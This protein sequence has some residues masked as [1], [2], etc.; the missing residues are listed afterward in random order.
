MASARPHHDRL[1]IRGG[2]RPAALALGRVHRSAQQSQPL[3]VTTAITTAEQRFSAAVSQRLRQLGALTTG[4]PRRRH[5]R[6]LGEGEVLL[7][8][9]GNRAA[10]IVGDLNHISVRKSHP[11]AG[12]CSTTR[13]ACRP[14]TRV[15]SSRALRPR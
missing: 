10:K 9:A 15:R 4:R 14:R 5:H 13:S 6:D 7:S 12:S 2:R 1:L 3:F 8:A 11:L